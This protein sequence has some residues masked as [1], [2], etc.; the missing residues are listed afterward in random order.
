MAVGTALSGVLSTNYDPAD[1]SAERV[2]FLSVGLGVIAV[3]GVM[4]ALLPWI[5]RRIGGGER[6]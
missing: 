3:A 2:Y 1:A 6:R 4:T 5:G